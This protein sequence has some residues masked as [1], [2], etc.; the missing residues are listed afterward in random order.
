MVH[1]GSVHEGGT[2]WHRY[3]SGERE[4]GGDGGEGGEGLDCVLKLKLLSLKPPSFHCAGMGMFPYHIGGTWAPTGHPAGERSRVRE[5][6]PTG[7]VPDKRPHALV[8]PPPGMPLKLT[9]PPCTA[10]VLNPSQGAAGSETLFGGVVRMIRNFP[11]F[12]TDAT[13]FAGPVCPH[14][15]RET[16]VGGWPT[17]KLAMQEGDWS[18]CVHT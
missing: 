15:G 8:A 2:R 12:Q 14:Q 9:T 11:L 10:R 13:L 1:H 7:T 3:F 17:Y 5:L 16:G 6:A 18:R 4:G